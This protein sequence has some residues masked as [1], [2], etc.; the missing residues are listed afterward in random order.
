VLLHFQFTLSV[1]FQEISGPARG[2]MVIAASMHGLLQPT[3]SHNHKVV[4]SASAEIVGT[5]EGQWRDHDLDVGSGQGHIHIHNTCRTTS[6]PNHLTVAS[7]T[8]EIW[9]FEFR[10][11]STFGKVWTLVIAFLQG[12]SKIGLW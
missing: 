12:N 7:R 3:C 5:S 8:T 2:L 9:P 4:A 10:E 1:G 11:I 6:M